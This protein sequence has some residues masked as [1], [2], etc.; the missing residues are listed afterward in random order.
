MTKEKHE[1][2]RIYTPASS[3]RNPRVLIGEM[4]RDL[5]QSRELAWQL[6]VRDIRAMYRQSILGIL[7]AFILPL[8]T[9]ITW[10]FLQ[11]SGVVSVGTTGIPYPVYV[12]T[13]TMLWAIFSESVQMPLQK[14]L[15]S[16]ALLAKINF[17]REALILSGFYQA[18]FNASIKI[19]ADDLGVWPLLGFPFLTW[20]FILFPVGDVWL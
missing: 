12:F 20:K 4:M 15:A 13:G 3:F 17:P 16:K 9:T 14:T 11:N 7:W 10:I 8:M 6:A 5:L 2:V 19:V 1:V 18:C